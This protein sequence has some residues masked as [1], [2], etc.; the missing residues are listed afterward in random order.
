MN[1]R[2]ILAGTSGAILSTVAGC[3]GMR[4]ESDDQDE[5]PPQRQERPE[6][7]E[8]VTG[9]T[10]V[11]FIDEHESAAYHNSFLDDGSRPD[12]LSVGCSASLDREIDDDFYVVGS[13]GGSIQNGRDIIDIATERRVYRVTESEFQRLTIEDVSGGATRVEDVS[14]YVITVANFDTTDHELRITI[15]SRTEPDDASR[16]ATDVFDDP[17]AIA[18]ETAIGWQFGITTGDQ[19]LVVERTDGRLETFEWTVRNDFGGITIYVT[20]EGEIDIDTIPFE[21]L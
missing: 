15:P 17:H 16:G 3:F 5:E 12:S 7:P 14:A 13:C 11:D 6:F 20:P 4:S 2:R 9:E 1:R 8:T 21:A 19:E 10:A 18:G